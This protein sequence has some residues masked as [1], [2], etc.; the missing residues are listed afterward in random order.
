[1]KQRTLKDIVSVKGKGLHTGKQI[2]MELVPASVNTGIVFVRTDLNDQVFIKVSPEVVLSPE[3]YP[4]RTSLGYKGVIIHTIEHLMAVLCGLMIDNVIVKLSGEEVPGFDGSG[5]ILTELIKKV[6]IQ[7]QEDVKKYLTITEPIYLRHQNAFLACFPYEGLKIDYL[8]DYNHPFLK[9][10]FIEFELT[11][12]N[13][14][15]EICFARTFCLEEEVDYLRG[16][17]LGKGADYSNTLVVSKRGVI[18]NELYC[19]DEFVRHKLLDCLGDFS[20]LG[21]PIQGHIITHKS[22]HTLNH[23]FIEKFLE[24]KDS[25][26]TGPARMEQYT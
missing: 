5:K 17:G 21:M 2:R 10:Q 7:E 23:L 24:N 20:L 19:E 8:L 6:G 4:R 1:M 15:K 13:F 12:E 16:L 3:E 26:E 11:P 18:N 14:E 25:W 22:G 9:K